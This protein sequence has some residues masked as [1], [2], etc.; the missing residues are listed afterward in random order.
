MAAIAAALAK[1]VWRS[2]LRPV[3]WVRLF[4]A[5]AVACT[6]A[7]IGGLVVLGHDGRMSTYAA[8][9]LAAALGLWAV[10]FGPLRR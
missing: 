1:V 3:P 6:L 4:A 10:G 9:V 5:A 2:E 7:L 8:M